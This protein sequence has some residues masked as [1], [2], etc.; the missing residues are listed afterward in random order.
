VPSGNPVKVS[1]SAK[2]RKA[3]SSMISN[4]PTGNKQTSFTEASRYGGV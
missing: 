1:S 4:I 3:V 2:V